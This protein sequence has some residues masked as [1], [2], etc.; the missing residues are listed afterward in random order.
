MNS[1]KFKAFIQTLNDPDASLTEIDFKK[2]LAFFLLEQKNLCLKDNILKQI[3]SKGI[4]K[5][6]FFL[7]SDDLR[8]RKLVLL[9][10]TLV[11]SNPKAKGLFMEKCGMALAQ[12]KVFLSRA[13][14]L[15]R[16]LSPVVFFTKLKRKEAQQ[17]PTSRNSLFWFISLSKISDETLSSED[18]IFEQF[19]ESNIV[20]S[21][22]G[23]FKLENVPDPVQNLC[24]ISVSHSDLKIYSEKP[25]PESEDPMAQSQIAESP[26]A[27]SNFDVGRYD[28]V[29]GQRGRT[30][31]SPSR[32]AQSM[33]ESRPPPKRP[34]TSA[35][36]H[37]RVKAEELASKSPVK[38]GEAK[39]ERNEAS[40]FSASQIENNPRRTNAKSPI[41]R[42]ET[43]PKKVGPSKS[44]VNV[45]TTTVVE[46]SSPTKTLF[47]KI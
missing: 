21:S 45:R 31:A 44:P 3:K 5:L 18:F 16:T 12:G 29:G 15:S 47:R 27:Q 26:M 7:E 37:S 11:L 34:V 22:E 8:M 42:Y 43:L 9:F 40:F 35:R 4:T 13:K 23:D 10:I 32:M 30:E 38:K 6:L 46:R 19:F 33:V 28:S 1:Q 17:S 14:H 41:P 2:I 39:N 20:I 24:G 25:D 36:P